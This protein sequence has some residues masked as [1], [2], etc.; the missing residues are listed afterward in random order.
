MHMIREEKIMNDTPE[1]ERPDDLS[2]KL[3]AIRPPE[4]PMDLA[5]EL[6]RIAGNISKI[7]AEAN[8][9]K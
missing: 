7:A 2:A 5:A 4:L 3:D 1:V 9:G 6:W 8:R